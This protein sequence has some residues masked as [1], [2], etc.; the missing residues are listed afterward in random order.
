MTKILTVTGFAQDSSLISKSLDLPSNAYNYLNKELQD[1]VLDQDYDMLIGWSLGGCVALELAKKYHIKK[2]ILIATPFH[3]KDSSKQVTQEFATAPQEFLKKF[4]KLLYFGDKNYRHIA[5]ELNIA[6][7]YDL[8]K[9]NKWL[10]YLY[11]FN[12]QLY[13]SFTGELLI[14]HG[15]QDAIIPASEAEY[16]QTLFKTENIVY[17]KEAGH[18]P[19]L[20]DKKLFNKL[21]NEFYAR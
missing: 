6:T 17:F 8:N 19:F 18:V 10:A 5:K 15:N 12:A 14:I 9:L 2:L 13:A 11:D 16:Y 1:L 3:L 4:T 20:H 7:N 21:V